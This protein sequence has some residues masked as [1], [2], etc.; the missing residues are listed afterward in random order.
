MKSLY[1]IIGLFLG[2][3]EVALCLRKTQYKTHTF[4]KKKASCEYYHNIAK[5]KQMRS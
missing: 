1:K 5:F 2:Y 3:I 4:P